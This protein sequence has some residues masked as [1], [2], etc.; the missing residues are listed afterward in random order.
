MKALMKLKPMFAIDPRSVGPCPSVVARPP[1]PRMSSPCKLL[2][3]LLLVP[4]AG[5]GEAMANATGTAKAPPGG[6]TANHERL[7]GTIELD[8]GNG[9]AVLR[10]M[11]TTLDV[12]LGKQV[13]ARLESGQGQRQIE[14][15]NQRVQAATGGKGPDMA[16]Q[17]QAIADSYAGKTVYTSDIRHVAIVGQY[18]VS[19]DAK[20]PQGART[21]LSLRLHEKDFSLKSAT[22]SYYP[23]AADMFSAFASA[24]SGPDAVSVRIDSFERINDTTFAM[25]GSFQ[26]SH[27]KPAALAKKLQGRSLD[28][29]QGRFSFAEIPLKPGL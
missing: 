17:V 29:V 11:A 25:Q 7:Q 12:Q 6:A 15:A 16:G 4:L 3:C 21:V 22:L 26:A 10:S 19:L 13:A 5:C 9:L 1:A 28:R 2:A 27:L 20:L 8:A 14:R 23:D 18:T 24:K